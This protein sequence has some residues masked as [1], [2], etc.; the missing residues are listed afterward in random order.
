MKEE[1]GYEFETQTDEQIQL[2]ANG[3][4]ICSMKCVLDSKCP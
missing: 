3:F 1:D 2:T 4:S